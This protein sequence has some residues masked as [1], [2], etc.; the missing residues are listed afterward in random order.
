[1][2]DCAPERNPSNA[3]AILTEIAK[4]MRARRRQRRDSWMEDA[5]DLAKARE[6]CP[7]GGWSAFLKEA[8]IEERTASNMLRL[9]P[10]K[11]E[12]VSDLGGIRK[13]LDYLSAIAAAR[14]WWEAWRDA[15]P[16]DSAERS[17]IV[18]A[19]PDGP[20]SGKAWLDFG[21][22]IAAAETDEERRAAYEL[23]PWR[24]AMLA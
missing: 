24:E 17:A 10:F 16:E 9:A 13:T 14:G 19:M 12:T 23:R 21:D 1:M 7:H 3:D 11:S 8:D 4:R 18:Q 6:V 2:T 22:A 5:R 15:T 20:I